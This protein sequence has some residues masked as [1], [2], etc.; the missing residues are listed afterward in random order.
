M[1]SILVPA[2]ANPPS[3]SLLLYATPVRAGFPSPATDYI[4]QPIDLN[5]LIV[6]D[7]AATFFLR[8]QGDS[9]RDAGI[10]DGSR[11]AVEG[12]RQPA[13]GDIVVASLEGEFT[14]KRF[15]RSPRGC[16][17]R[18]ANPDYPVIRVPPG[19]DLQVFGVVVAVI[20]RFLP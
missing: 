10:L 19:G 1:N 16:E 14:L 7:A 2:L 18:P 12:G 17:L 20:T 13:S 5:A 15:H 9:M 6:R 4:D 3:R 8:V 11:V